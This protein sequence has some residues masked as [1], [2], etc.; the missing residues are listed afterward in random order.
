VSSRRGTSIYDRDLDQVGANYSPLTPITFL[1]RSAAVY[2]EKTAV[3]HG[4]T[5]LSYA[6][7]YERCRKLA[8]ALSRRGIGLGDTV[9]VMASNVPALL[10][11]HYGVPMTG[12]VLNALNYRLDAGTIAFILGHA[13]SKLLI[14][15]R[16]FSDTIA[17]ALEQMEKPPAV[18]DID[19]PLYS[20]G[21]L[22][23]EK[24]YEDLLREGSSDDPYQTPSDEWQALSLC[25]T[26]GT[27]GNPKG[28]VYHH[29]GAYLSAMGEILAFGLNDRSTYL[30]TLPMFHCNGWTYT[31]GVTAAAGTHVCLRHVDPAVVFSMIKEHA[32]THMCGAPVVLN[33][34]IH[35]P[36]EH[37]VRFD[38][39]VDVA[40][41]GAAPP[42]RV[43]SAMEELGF[44]V[45]HLYGL[46]ETYG[47]ATLCAWQSD[48]S[49]LDAE[50]R[51]AMMA[52]QGVVYHT[53]QEFMVA[54]G[55]SMEQV[56]SDGS[57]MGELMISGNT[58]MK[59]YYSLPRR[60][61]PHRRS[62][63]PPPGRLRRDQR[64]RQGHHHQRRRERLQPRGRGAPL[65]APRYH[66]SRRGRTP[67][68]F[69]GRN[70]VRLRHL[71]ARHKRS[72]RRRDHHLVPRQDRP[73][74]D[75][76][77]DRLRPP[78][79]DVN[80]KDPEIRASGTGKGV[81]NDL[82]VVLPNYP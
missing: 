55:E 42:S 4:N 39:T 76:E 5:R 68:R 56:P 53:L 41:G 1:E 71:E 46:T 26:S 23:G 66:G 15:D 18:I 35:A 13:Q 70:R 33:L 52:R 57:T 29:R 81:V 79:Q 77:D 31:W 10:E 3:I 75:P 21:K 74:Q 30:W 32:V 9:S 2:P 62:R 59:G 72:Q 36:A 63:R 6:Q 82:G 17:A 44:R 60:L 64:S 22:L 80:R 51:A 12:A 47:P 58:V 65:Q 49:D 28:V 38:H 50:A 73:F 45:L 37:R 7:F 67:R 48:W 61:V 19:D 78:A 43:I 40:T 69:L 16:E 8:S 54:D 11:A 24:D 27:T 34:L 25:Y 20:G 14:T